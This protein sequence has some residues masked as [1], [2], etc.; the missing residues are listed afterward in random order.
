MGLYCVFGPLGRAIAACHTLFIIA[1]LIAIAAAIIVAIRTFRKKAMISVLLVT[2][3][4]L[5]MVF[6][7]ISNILAL[8]TEVHVACSNNLLPALLIAESVLAVI[9]D[10]LL[11]AALLLLPH[12]LGRLPIL[13]IIVQGVT[14]VIVWALMLA[15]VIS[16][17]FTTSIDLFRATYALYG[18]AVCLTI[19]LSFYGLIAQRPKGTAQIY[20]LV[21]LAV[22]SCLM[23]VWF[24]LTFVWFIPLATVHGLDGSSY[25]VVEVDKVIRVIVLGY[26]IELARFAVLLL[27]TLAAELG[28]AGVQDQ[29][30]YEA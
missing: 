2:V 5:A 23:V 28:G 22:I 30:A 21:V 17:W 20:H 9:G 12:H 3:A 4:T 1:Y 27:I 19:G 29:E 6:Y 11:L 8:A 16:R 7:C 13:A 25:M 26:L 15:W 10:A 18:F 24:V 14:F